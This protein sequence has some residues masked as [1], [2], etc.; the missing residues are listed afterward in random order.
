[1]LELAPYPTES[2]RSV[3]GQLLDTCL[4]EAPRPVPTSRVCPQNAVHFPVPG[5]VPRTAQ[6]EPG[7]TRCAAAGATAAPAL[8]GV[9]W[10][11]GKQPAEPHNK[12]TLSDRHCTPYAMALVNTR[13]LWHC[14]QVFSCL[15]HHL[16]P[17]A[18]LHRAAPAHPRPSKQ[19]SS[20]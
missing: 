5:G 6:E 17:Q 7:R 16:Y 20:D 1:M 13:H 8:G 11:R 9:G 19:R 15:H 14:H 4:G 3:L 10:A 2:K 18:A 12:H